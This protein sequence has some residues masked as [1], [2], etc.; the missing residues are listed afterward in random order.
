MPLVTTT[1]GAFPKP[2][3]VTL[4]DWFRGPSTLGADATIATSRLSSAAAQDESVACGIREVV[5]AQ[6]TAGV[7][8]PTDGEVRR[9][10]YVHYH[11]RHL[12]GFDFDRLTPKL[13]RDRT[14]QAELPTVVGPIS[15]QAPFLVADYR[16]AQS[17]TD[18][19]I[20]ITLP[21]PMTIMDST[22][23]AFYFDDLAWGHALALA[24][25]HEARALIAAGCRHL[26]IDEPVFA[27]YPERALGY[28]FDLLEVVLEGIPET[29][30]RVLHMCCGYPDRLDNPSYP[31]ADPAAYL[32]LAPAVDASSCDAVSLEDAHRPVDRRVFEAL[33]STTVILGA[34]RIA[35]SRVE[36]AAEI[37]GRV[38]GVLAHVP[39]ARLQ[40]APDCGLGMLP[41]AIALAKLRQ[42]R[43]AADVFDR[44]V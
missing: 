43:R 22:A 16:I 23:D 5:A 1:I 9:E 24:L 8:I 34:V 29:V 11:C 40:L 19:P 12:E 35:T 26:Q 17:A 25:N 30:T 14:W 37:A 28:G 7:D 39:A 6:V 18:R 31:K 42:M 27:R 21:G 32:Q 10:N 13:V 15:P 41:R 20:K 33:A 2:E 4:P 36:T 38:E 44:D 3:S